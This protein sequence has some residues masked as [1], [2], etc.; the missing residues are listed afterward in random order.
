M[1]LPRIFLGYIFKEFPINPCLVLKFSIIACIFYFCKI[2]I[3]R[4][5]DHD[6][7]V[8]YFSKKLLDVLLLKD[9]FILIGF[10][11]S[12]VI[13]DMDSQRVVHQLTLN[14]PSI[15]EYNIIF[16]E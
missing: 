7:K 2:M 12:I 8:F 9:N 10:S 16:I 1:L 13:V 5:G 3:S 14:V 4:F 6:K 11:D 15:R